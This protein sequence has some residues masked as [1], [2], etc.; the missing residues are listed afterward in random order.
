MLDILTYIRQPQAQCCVCCHTHGNYSCN[1][2]CP[3]VC[4]STWLSPATCGNHSEAPAP[5]LWFFSLRPALLS[6]APPALRGGLN[7][8]QVVAKIKSI[9]DPNSRL[10][11]FFDCRLA[12][13]SSIDLCEIWSPDLA[14]G[15]A[16]FEIGTSGNTT[17][18]GET[19]NDPRL[20]PK[21]IDAL[22]LYLFFS[23]TFLRLQ[24]IVPSGS[25]TYGFQALCCSRPPRRG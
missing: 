24:M 18:T 15:G 5:S 9:V 20:R 22:D 12:L 13:Y 21:T 17:N 2:I 10:A 6:T 11:L 4:H 1:L 16:Q 23:R 3:C 25:P 14:A 8:C 7:C 19:A